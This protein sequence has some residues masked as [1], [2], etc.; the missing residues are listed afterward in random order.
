MVIS[1]HNHNS[2]RVLFDETTS[3]YFI[4]K[5]Y[6]YLSTEN[7]QLWE[8][9]PCQSHRQTFVP[10]Q[11]LLILSPITGTW[12]GEWAVKERK[13]RRQACSDCFSDG[14]S[15]DRLA[16]ATSLLGDEWQTNYM[17]RRLSLK[18]KRLDR[19]RSIDT[20]IQQSP[21]TACTLLLRVL[22]PTDLKSCHNSPSY[23]VHNTAFHGY[24][25]LY[26]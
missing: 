25:S 1:N 2:F 15:I 8:P 18:R 12:C 6:L 23:V 9:A 20:P 14:W 24:G 4:W 10:L 22:Q 11:M 19:P 13:T 7:G 3:V 5:I 26:S 16:R 17:D 21:H